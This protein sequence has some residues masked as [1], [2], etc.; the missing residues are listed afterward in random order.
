V[1]VVST[2]L[3]AV[4]A[5]L[6]AAGAAMIVRARE[7]RHQIQRELADQEIVFPPAKD[8]PDALAAH[9]G[10]RV[11]SGEQA[12]AYAE[13]IGV[14]V[15]KATAGRT[16]SQIVGEWHASG[17]TD[18]RLTRLRETAFMGHTLRGSLLGAYQAWQI[19]TLT[20]G[21]GALLGAIGVVFV[22]LGATGL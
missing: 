12:R 3:F 2:L 22:A 6:L 17:R 5:A 14:H 9:A 16:Y 13:L 21:L 18:E 20:I 19:T 1:D 11:A 8:L 10:A 15:A 4:G 7:G